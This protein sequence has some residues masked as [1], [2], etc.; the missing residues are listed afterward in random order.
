MTSS[1]GRIN[2][3][4]KHI[5]SPLTSLFRKVSTHRPSGGSTSQTPT[6]PQSPLIHTRFR[7]S[8]ATTSSYDTSRFQDEESVVVDVRT[9]LFYSL[10]LVHS[11]DHPQPP[12]KPSNLPGTRHQQYHAAELEAHAHPSGSIPAIEIHPSPDHGVSTVAHNIQPIGVI[13]S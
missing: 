9:F 6:Q 3:D 1:S 10:P 13:L 2:F 8:V 12:N 4:D 11:H 5:S 7:G